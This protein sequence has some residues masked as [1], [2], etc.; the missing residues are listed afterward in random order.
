MKSKYP[1]PRWKCWGT[2]FRPFHHKGVSLRTPFIA[3]GMWWN[4]YDISGYHYKWMFRLA[5]GWHSP[6][7]AGDMYYPH[8]WEIGKKRDVKTR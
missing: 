7:L 4:F 2:D 6:I 5:L 1:L 3:V 8:Y